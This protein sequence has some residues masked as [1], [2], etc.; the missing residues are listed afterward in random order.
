MTQWGREEDRFL[1]IFIGGIFIIMAI[2]F[3]PLMTVV[4]WATAV[5]V[6][7]MP[8]HRRLSKI[9]SPAVSATF[10]TLWVLLGVLLVLSAVANVIYFNIQYIGTIATSLTRGFEYTGLPT[11]LPPLSET[12]LNNMPQTI[13]QMFLQAV[14]PSGSSPVLLGLQIVI[15][16]LLLSMLLFYGEKI[17]DALMH[18]LPDTVQAAIGKLAEITGNTIYALLIIQITAAAIC[19]LLAV[20]FFTFLGYGHVLLFSTMIGLAMLIPLIGAQFFL[21][22]FL[23]YMIA[24]GDYRSAAIIVLIGYPLLSGWIDFY[25]RPMMMGKRVA[26]HPVCMMI[27]ILA[28]VPFMGLVGFILGPVLVALGVTG[29][30]IYTED[31]VRHAPPDRPV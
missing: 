26:V 21:L 8:F 29:F 12:Q 20:P 11:F 1:L 31:I 19:F 24:L 10:L 9:V 25:Y 13:V 14:T 27:G 5:A 3:L 2:A 30:R 22:I 4:V 28:G 23:L 17:W 7:L 6:A 16:F 15:F 18:P